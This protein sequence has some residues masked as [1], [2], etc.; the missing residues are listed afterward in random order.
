MIE[1]WFFYGLAMLA[2]AATVFLLLMGPAVACYSWQI[3]SCSEERPTSTLNHLVETR[4]TRD[5]VVS[6]G[7]TRLQEV[8]QH[9]EVERVFVLGTPEFPY[10]HWLHT[11]ESNV[12]GTD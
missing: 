2:I 12:F 1:K 5:A 9:I 7:I 10:R 3:Y 11:G 4:R 8:E 6:R